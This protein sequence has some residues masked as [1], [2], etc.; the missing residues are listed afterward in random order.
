MSKLLF[1]ET[2]VFRQKILWL[3]L[4]VITGGSIV[5]FSIAIYNQIISNEQFGDKPISDSALIIG[6]LLVIGFAIFLSW[7]FYSIKLEIRISEEK[8]QYKFWP[9]IRDFKNISFNN[10]QSIELEKYRPIMEYGGWGY[11]FSMKGRGLCLNVSKNMGLR[12]KMK[13][14]FELLLGTQKTDELYPIV[15]ELKKEYQLNKKD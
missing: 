3:L 9:F 6:F 11:R 15:E 5:L 2:Q 10:I 13:D 14:G 12:I 7:F 1:E 4:L 8:L